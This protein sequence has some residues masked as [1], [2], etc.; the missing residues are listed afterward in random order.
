MTRPQTATTA[1]RQSRGDLITAENAAPSGLSGELFWSVAC[2]RVVGW[3]WPGG[4][5][6]AVGCGAGFGSFIQDSITIAACS[7]AGR[8]ITRVPSLSASFLNES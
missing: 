3:A 7:K 1:T 4:L 8:G 2:G 5:G 6:G